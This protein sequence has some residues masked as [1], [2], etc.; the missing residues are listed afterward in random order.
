MKPGQFM[1]LKNLLILTSISFIVFSTVWFSP[2]LSSRP[3]QQTNPANPWA[4]PDLPPLPTTNATIKASPFNITATVGTNVTIRFTIS[5]ATDVYAWQL[6]VRWNPS[7]LKFV[8]LTSG[9]FLN[10]YEDVEITQIP[11][12]YVDIQ[13]SLSKVETDKGAMRVYRHY[14][15][16]SKMLIGETRLGPHPGISGN[17]TLC[18]VVFQVIG[19]GSTALDIATA[20]NFSSY[21][22]D[23]YIRELPSIMQNGL[24]MGMESPE[25]ISD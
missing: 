9:D 12:E 25:Y 13:I 10:K 21:L 18:S 7:V 14:I 1:N 16:E 2:A 20:S 19:Q 15:D 24:I 4:S 17:G 11:D 23:S 22:L 8:T 5:D 6:Y 3:E